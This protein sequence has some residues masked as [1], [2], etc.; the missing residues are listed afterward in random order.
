MLYDIGFLI[1]SV[2]YLPTLIFKGKL[3]KDF[4]ERFGAY[5]DEKLSALKAGRDIIWIQ[6]VSV[7]EVALCKSLIPA[8]RETFPASTIVFST[9]TRTG[10]ELARKLFSKEAVIIYFPL[11]LSFIVKKAA[12]IIRPSLYV[13]IETEIWPNFLEEMCKGK[14]PSILINGR[15]SD[16]S[17]GKYMIARR[18]LKKTLENIG[19]FC[20]QSELDAERIISLGA[21][22]DRVLVTGNMKLD[23]EIRSDVRAMET[24]KEAISLKADEELFVAGSTHPGEEEIII[25]SFKE[26]QKDFPKLK[27]L[28]A[29]RHIERASEVEA[30]VKKKG[31]RPIKPPDF[32]LHPAPHNLHPIFILD[33]IGYL[34]SAY[35][36]AS[37]V[38]IGGSLVKHGGQNPIEPAMHEKSVIFGPYM[39]N[40]KEVTKL[41]VDSG[42]AIQVFGKEDLV[43]RAK[44]LLQ[45]KDMRLRTGRLAKTAVISGRGATEKNI[46]IIK[47][48]A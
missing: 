43:R 28:I 21:T 6:A 10:N 30:V 35:S 7:G 23:V 40:F 13:M 36:F 3:H 47:K 26:L 1:F 17:Y 44:E 5:S 48:Y 25:E 9:I 19:C 11:D 4:G 34:D 32:S 33:K 14:V 24:L 15:I 39:F 18:F 27:L 41:L 46:E 12:G 42:G 29:P 37:L 16:R 45:D 8:L 31:F 2:F 38:F 22:S 20:M